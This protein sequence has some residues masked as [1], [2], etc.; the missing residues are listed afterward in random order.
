MLPVLNQRGWFN[1]PIGFFGP[2]FDRFLH[3]LNEETDEL[4]ASYPVDVR[5]DDESLH[6][7]AELPGFKADEIDVTVDRGV[8]RIS[9]ERKSEE[10]DGKHHLK[11]RRYTSVSRSFT[12]PTR[13][14][15]DHVE[16]RLD[17][18]VLMLTLPKSK[19][20]KPARI[21]VHN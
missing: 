20:V 10:K 11:E 21:E 19:E 5:E 16:A 15:T 17:D 2:E 6:V 18:G 3:N 9:A 12:L 7:E 14:Q 4:T 1:R 13:V 8:L